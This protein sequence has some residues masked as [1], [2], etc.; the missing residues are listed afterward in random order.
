MTHDQQP[1]SIERQIE[2]AKI[3]MVDAALEIE[4][5]NI[6]HQMSKQLLIELQQKQRGQKSE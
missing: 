6:R 2:L 3:A 5:A 1:L 4:Q